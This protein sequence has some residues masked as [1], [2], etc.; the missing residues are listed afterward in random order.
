VLDVD[1]TDVAAP[2]IA[3]AAGACIIYF[4]CTLVA[5][6]VGTVLALIGA[7]AIYRVMNDRKRREE[8]N[9]PKQ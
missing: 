7:L 3:P 9:P 8:P 5:W 1:V 6:V 4:Y 2:F